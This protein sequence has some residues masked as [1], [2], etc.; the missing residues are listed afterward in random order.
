VLRRFAL[1]AAALRM[2]VEAGLWPWSVESS[3]RA[4]LACALRWAKDKDASVA[5]LEEKAAEQKLRAVILAKRDANQLIVLNKLP[6]KGGGLL[7]PAPEHAAMY[8]DLETFKR[9]GFGFI[10]NDGDNTRILLFHPDALPRLAAGCDI[11]H[12]AFVDYLQRARL[13]EIKREKVNGKADL[14]Y[15]LPATFLS[16]DAPSNEMSSAEPLN[17]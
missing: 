12:D 10:K 14:Y 15:V 11:E 3:D 5:T 4:I 6:G 2:A 8:A 17:R 13:L 1:L 7:V 16:R 9:S